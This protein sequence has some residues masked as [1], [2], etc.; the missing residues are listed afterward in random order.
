MGV[1]TV[2]TGT[3]TRQ[4]GTFACELQLTSDNIT[5]ASTTMKLVNMPKLT[6][7]FEMQDE[8]NDLSELRVNLSEISLSIFDTLGNGST[9]FSYIDSMTL[10]DTIQVKV[11]V[12]SG[13]DFFIT[14][15]ESCNYDWFSR[16]VTFK[17]QPALKYDIE[18]TNYASI[19]LPDY[20]SNENFVA[21]GDV[22]KAFLE[23]QG[24]SPTVK[25]KGHF[26]T[27]DI[28][29]ITG[30]PVDPPPR[31]MIFEEVYVGTYA[32]AQDITL[33]FSLVEGAIIG[34][35]LGY[36]F[37][38]R[39]NFAGTDPDDFQTINA[40]NLKSFGVEFNKRSIRNFNTSFFI[41]DNLGTGV[42]TD[43][44]VNDDEVLDS[45]GTQDIDILYRINDMNTIEYSSGWQLQ[46]AGTSVLTTSNMQ[47]ITNNAKAG[48]KAA[49][50][51][52]SSYSVK[53]EIFGIETLKPY[54]YILFGSGIHETVNG[55]KVRPSY[56]EYDLEN[57]I[58]KGEGYIIG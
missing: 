12:N 26:F 6:Q 35:M 36:S 40:S 3:I 41:Q 54:Q 31:Y 34:S 7:D 11:T 27:H 19:N 50:G 39:R 38:V 53:F 2:S 32:Q 20:V 25:V 28:D 9:L 23:S 56:I 48:Y 42:D 4:F 44:G 15:K 51:L 46:N 5:T 37:Y 33:G 45:Q 14:K 18:V 29:D 17:A 55:K 10:S 47:T 57:D 16:K 58:V 13:V 43:I 49:L 30:V 24:S 52:S 8:L 21:P 1:L 22:I